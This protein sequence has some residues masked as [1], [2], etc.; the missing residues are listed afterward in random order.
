MGNYQVRFWRAAAL[1]RESLTLILDGTVRQPASG[2]RF[3]QH[4]LEQQI[5][6]GADK[7]VAH[8]HKQG[9]IVI[10]ISNQAGV[11]A[12][13]K[14]LKDAIAEQRYTLELFPQLTAI[15]FCPGF[16]GRHCWLVERGFDAKPIH[17]AD[18]AAEFIGKFRKPQPGMLN[19]AIRMSGAESEKQSY[20]YI[21]DREEDKLAAEAA[22]VSFIRAE[23]WLKQCQF[24]PDSTQ[25]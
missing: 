21:G 8:Y 13:H 18:W 5:I 3:I 2:E 4:P 19:A 11:E 6:V 14:T 15:Y 1:V 20:L 24:L 10:G 23:I 22:N 9:W 12:Q 25:S 16:K 17:I 7:G